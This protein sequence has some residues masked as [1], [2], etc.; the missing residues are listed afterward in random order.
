[1]TLST[2]VYVLDPADHR[3]VF[4]FCQALVAKY[5]DH[6]RPPHQQRWS[7]EAR[8]TYRD[9]TWA[10][11]PDSPWCVSNELGQGL[12]A[13]LLVTYRPDAP[14]RTPEQAAAC[15]E[16]CDEDCDRSHSYR[17]A[18]W[19]DVDFDTAYGYS[20]HDMGC[21]DLHALLVVVELGQWLDSLSVRWE[22]QNEFTGDVHGGEDRYRRLIDLSSGGFEASA[23]FQ[24]TVLPAIAASSEGGR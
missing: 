2:H 17:R 20:V 5:D 4:R 10:I 22:W 12:P 1:M 13:W 15:D 7:A 3:E 11:R 24:S 6:S 19:L 8:E 21:G 14:L 9:G 18:C 23:W 16:D